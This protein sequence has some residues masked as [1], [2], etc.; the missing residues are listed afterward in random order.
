MP[1][2]FTGLEIPKEI[3][4]SLDLV[5]DGNAVRVLADAQHTEKHDLFELAEHD[6]TWLVRQCLVYD[7][8]TVA[9]KLSCSFQWRR[10]SPASR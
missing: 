3:G 4:A 7:Q 10:A 1:R 9:R 8:V 6:E 2:L 5:V